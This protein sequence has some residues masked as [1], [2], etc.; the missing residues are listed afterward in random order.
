[1]VRWILV[2]ILAVP[3][4]S[5]RGRH[6]PRVVKRRAGGFPAKPRDAAPVA[7]ASRTVRY[8][9]CI[10]IVPPAQPTRTARKGSGRKPTARKPA[11]RKPAKPPAPRRPPTRPEPEAFWLRH[12]RAWRASGLPR[13]DYCQRHGLEQPP[14]NHWVAKLRDAFRRPTKTTPEAT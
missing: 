7:R 2:E 14:F 5:S 3:A 13:A 11:G 1:M 6:N 12:V 4:E 10:R 9:D 8:A